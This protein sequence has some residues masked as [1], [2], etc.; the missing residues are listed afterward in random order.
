MSNVFY[1]L[2]ELGAEKI[3]ISL[4]KLHLLIASLDEANEKL[5]AAKKDGGPLSDF[6]WCYSKGWL[7]K[8]SK[9]Y[10]EYY[11]QNNW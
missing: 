3:T 11:R 9:E 8:N 4:E 10:K 5:N 2:S 6:V 7:N 1:R